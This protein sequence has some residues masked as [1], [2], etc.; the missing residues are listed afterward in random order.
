MEAPHKGIQDS[1]RWKRS[2]AGSDTWLVCSF[3]LFRSS[4]QLIS[5]AHLISI[6]SAHPQRRSNEAG[7]RKRATRLR[8]NSEHRE[9]VMQVRDMKFT[10]DTVLRCFRDG[11]SFEEF[12]RNLRS[13]QLDPLKHLNPLKVYSLPGQSRSTSGRRSS[14][15]ENTPC[16]SWICW[17]NGTRRHSGPC[18]GHAVVVH[19][20]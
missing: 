1:V 3:H 14:T 9:D 20:G 10:H 12:I 11:R 19:A 7:D 2:T 4:A 13:G 6:S 18:H 8:P 15:A 16:T 17:R 5:P